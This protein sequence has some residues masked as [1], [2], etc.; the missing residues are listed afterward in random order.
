MNSLSDRSIPSSFADLASL[1]ADRRRAAMLLALMDGRALTATELAAESEIAASTASGHLSQLVAGGILD[2]VKQGR[3]RYFRLRDAQTA[4][5]IE[6]LMGLSAR[7]H[8]AGCATGPDDSALRYARVCYDHLAGTC[9]VRLLQR[10][11]EATYLVADSTGLRLTE[12]GLAWC[13]TIGV[14]TAPWQGQRRAAC[15]HCLDWS[16]RRMHLAGALGA[17][18]LQRLLDLGHLQRQSQ[19]RAL[20]IDAAGERFIDTLALP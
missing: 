20:R 11:C 5:A 6:T 2:V 4:A 1:L 14:D 7:A 18:L 12:P 17:A 8:G 15:R 19:G 10:L 13:R 9:G 3:H 16:E